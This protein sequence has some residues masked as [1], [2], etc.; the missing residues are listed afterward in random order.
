[1]SLGLGQ[2]DMEIEELEL[3]NNTIDNTLLDFDN[4]IEIDKFVKKYR[5]RSN[6][7]PPFFTE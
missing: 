6:P 7:K 2:M 3:E 5:K 4:C 1:M